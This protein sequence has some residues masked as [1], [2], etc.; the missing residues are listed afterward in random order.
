MLTISLIFSLANAASKS[1]STHQHE[2]HEHVEHVRCQVHARGVCEVLVEIGEGPGGSQEVVHSLVQTL[3]G[4]TVL[5]G[6]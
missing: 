3:G 4:E 1:C 6:T 5:F 2:L